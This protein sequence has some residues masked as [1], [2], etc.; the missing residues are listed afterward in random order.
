MFRVHLEPMLRNRGYLVE[1][2]ESKP[3]SVG[4]AMFFR[5]SRFELVNKDHTDNINIFKKVPNN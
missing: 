3:Y 1:Y 2:E 4:V 5:T